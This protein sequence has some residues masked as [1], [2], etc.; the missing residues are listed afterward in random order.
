MEECTYTEWHDCL[1]C[2]GDLSLLSH[3]DYLQCILVTT[4]VLTLEI[5]YGLTILEKLDF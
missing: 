1:S 4:F 5:V 2:Q 3:P